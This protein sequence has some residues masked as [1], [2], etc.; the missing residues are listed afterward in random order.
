MSKSLIKARRT[1][2]GMSTTQIAHR[3]G[4]AQ[5]TAVRLEQSEE[6]KTISL[7]SL[8]RIAERLGYTLIYELR[9]N[10]GVKSKPSPK[11]SFKRLRGFSPLETALRDRDLEIARES[12]ALQRLKRG[13]ELSDFTRRLKCSNKSS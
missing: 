4:V 9:P 2:L 1:V 10:S 7:G 6:K 5:S 12:S 11:A 8:E 3:L 13:I